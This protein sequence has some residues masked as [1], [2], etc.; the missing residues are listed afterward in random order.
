MYFTPEP[1]I[2]CQYINIA[3]AG[4]NKMNQLASASEG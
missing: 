2:I 3:S 1:T 4:P